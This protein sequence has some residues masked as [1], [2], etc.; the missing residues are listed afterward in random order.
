MSNL[1]NLTYWLNLKEE[2][3]GMGM[4][5]LGVPTGSPESAAP[6]VTN[7]PQE[8]PQSMDQNQSNKED[9][10][11]KDPQVPD[12]DDVSDD[13]SDFNDWKKEFFDSS[14][15]GDTNELLDLIGQ[16]RDRNLKAADKRF[17]EDNLQI[18][19][20]RQDANFD[21]ASKEIRRLITQQL[22]RN[23][24]AISIMQHLDRTL[25][26]YP[27]I[28]NVLIKLA[29][30]G[31]LKAEYHRRVIGA[32]TGSI[33]MGSGGNK[34][35]LIFA[36]REYSIDISTRFY[37]TW[38]DISIGRWTLQESD[39]EEILSDA[40]LERLNEG[41]PEEKRVIRHRVCLES[42]AQKFANRAF[43]IYV[44]DP[45]D[46]TIHTF[47]W[48]IAEALREGYKEGKLVVRKRK[49]QEKDA[50]IDDNG[51]IIPLFSYSINYK[52]EEKELSDTGVMKYEEVPFMEQRDGALFLTASPETIQ[53]L[54][55]GMAGMLYA[56]KAYQGN[57][58]D[59]PIMM[60]CFPSTVEALMRRC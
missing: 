7:P 51:A 44:V 50:M 9:D 29:G 37:T 57:P 20:L 41:A 12:M 60:R 17:V 33:Q 24:P 53:E 10:F 28:N 23:T 11:S 21:K 52:K 22:D 14:I 36:A 26:S 43:L 40:E 56:S 32:L 59:L 54:S 16:V 18:T 39:P 38:G 3:G 34:Q 27:I 49:S 45:E 1:N 4:A 48:D 35:D 58:S 30:Q 2:D 6:S 46:G 15:K 8:Q 13:S 55:G 25:E 5:D 31:A 42:V 19:L 47:G